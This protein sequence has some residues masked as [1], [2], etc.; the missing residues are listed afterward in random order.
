MNVRLKGKGLGSCGAGG[1][2]GGECLRRSILVTVADSWESASWTV[3]RN[4]TVVW[5]A[6]WEKKGHH[7]QLLG[8]GALS[9]QPT[10]DLIC[11]CQQTLFSAQTLASFSLLELSF[12]Y[13]CIFLLN[14]L[15][16]INCLYFRKLDWW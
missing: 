14:T 6:A 9:S 8:K 13:N 3:T 7:H 4:S 15:H 11:G 12:E 2:R 1:T 5:W 16:L 10:P